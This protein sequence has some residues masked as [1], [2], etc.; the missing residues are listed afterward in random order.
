[1]KQCTL[2]I[3]GEELVTTDLISNTVLGEEPIT[4]AHRINVGG[5]MLTYAFWE[6]SCLDTESKFW[7]LVYSQND[8]WN[9]WSF[10]LD[11]H[12]SFAGALFS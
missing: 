11:C 7:F 8:S 10:T 5:S 9:V 2:R 12:S 1:M 4:Q 3:H 6:G